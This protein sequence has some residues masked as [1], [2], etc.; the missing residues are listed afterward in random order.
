MKIVRQTKNIRMH[1]GKSVSKVLAVFLAAGLC[2]G[3]LT[4]CGNDSEELSEKG[5][6]TRVIF[7]MGF[8][9]DEVFRIED[10]SCSRSEAMIYLTNTQNQYENVYGSEIWDVSLEDITLEDNVKDTVLAKLAQIKTMYLLA[11]EKEIVLE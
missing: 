5:N 2:V 4:A 7:T 6:N 9:E 10:V 8:D 11:E 1:G 3:S